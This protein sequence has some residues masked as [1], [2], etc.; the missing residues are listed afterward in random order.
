MFK[1]FCSDFFSHW[2]KIRST[3]KQNRKI[4]RCWERAIPQKGGILVC[5][6]AVVVVTICTTYKIIS[7]WYRKTWVNSHISIYKY[8]KKM[9]CIS[10]LK[11]DHKTT[12]H[13][14]FQWRK[15]LIVY[16]RKRTIFWN[17]E[18]SKQNHH[19][20]KK[21][22]VFQNLAIWHD[23]CCKVLSEKYTMIPK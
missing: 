11:K 21:C 3:F 9:T 10:I 6:I 7:T 1:R 14:K 4:T 8:V 19:V 23:V 16:I 20:F 22:L 18:V 2:K 15:Y 12:F 5:S 13:M 17:S